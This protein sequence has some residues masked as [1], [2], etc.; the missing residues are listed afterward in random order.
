[1]TRMLR[2]AVA[3]DEPDVLHYLRVMLPRLGHQV[4]AAAINGRELLELCRLQKPDLI[5]ADVRMPEMNGDVAI[6]QICQETPTPFIL[7]SAYGRP[8]ETPTEF[9]CVAHTFLT[10]PA[11]RRDLENAISLVYP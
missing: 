10:K 5:I 11:T 1:M 8:A 4:I 6:R 3:D 9:G 7:F 2:I